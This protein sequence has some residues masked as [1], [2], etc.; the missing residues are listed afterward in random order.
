MSSSNSG[1]VTDWGNTM[2][3]GLSDVGSFKAVLGLAV[4]ALIGFFLL[5]VGIYMMFTDNSN[6]YLHIKGLVV[7]SDCSKSQTTYNEKGYP[8][9]G[10][11]CNITVS[12]KIN[13]TVLSKIIYTNGS[14]TYI[15][16][17][18][19]DLMVEKENYENVLLSKMSG[20]VV[21]GLM[22]GGSVLMIGVAYLNYYLTQN[23]KVF[24]A[25]Q[26]ANTLTGLFR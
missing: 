21:G 23:Y 25:A 16:N 14:S 11:K 22:V 26:G 12:Y 19:I 9:E 8:I 15:K 5:V 20:M 4:A 1:P 17:E 24:A 3:S 2:Y 18:P 13:D 6:K 7:E 10:Y